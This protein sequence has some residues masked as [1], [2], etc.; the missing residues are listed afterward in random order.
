MKRGTSGYTEVGGGRS[1]NAVRHG[2]FGSRGRDRAILP[3]GTEIKT[4]SRR[5]FSTGTKK[6]GCP[7]NPTRSSTGP[8]MTTPITSPVLKSRWLLS[9]MSVDD[10]T[11]EARYVQDTTAI[12]T[13]LSG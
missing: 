3:N 8:K 5:I 12:L 4:N 13:V 9:R 11:R 2:V 10:T 7:K 6:T 1:N